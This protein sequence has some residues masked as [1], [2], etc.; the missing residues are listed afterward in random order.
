MS[1]GRFLLLVAVLVSVQGCE[2]LGRDDPMTHERKAE[3]AFEEQYKDLV[4]GAIKAVDGALEEESAGYPLIEEF[5]ADAGFTSTHPDVYIQN[6]KVHWHN[7]LSTG[8]QYIYRSIPSFGGNVRVTAVGQIDS[9]RPNCWGVVG[10]GDGID[11]QTVTGFAFGYR[12]GCSPGYRIDGMGA[13]LGDS[14]VH[15]V[16]IEAGTQYT[17]TSTI[18]DSA[19]LTVVGQGSVTGT[20][21]YA[22]SYDTLWVGWPV[23]A[24]SDPGECTGSIE[25]VIIEPL[26]R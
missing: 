21:A 19:T 4:G 9:V 24:S 15:S 16:L 1:G 8:Q 18:T 11:M 10:I 22:G 17:A 5:E 6:G 13:D 23:P 12:G 25:R 2:W 14:C 3:E 20:P 7:D 26:G